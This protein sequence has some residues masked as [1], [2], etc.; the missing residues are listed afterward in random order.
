M[1][2]RLLLAV[3]FFIA[4]TLLPWWAM[5]FLGVIF[6]V[7]FSWSYELLIW[8]LILLSLN[9][10]EKARFI[11]FLSLLLTLC[12][13]WCKTMVRKGGETRYTGA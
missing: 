4:A 8:S 2:W 12:I 1:M 11:F 9:M 7:C 10:H 3:L 13:P 5:I 6:L